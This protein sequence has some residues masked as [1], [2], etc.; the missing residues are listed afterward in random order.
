MGYM[1]VDRKGKRRSQKRIELGA[2]DYSLAVNSEC[3]PTRIMIRFYRREAE[4]VDVFT[5]IY[6]DI[7]EL[8][9]LQF[10]G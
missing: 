6:I 5:S 7:A 2:L 9:N 8:A 3:S 10:R 1:T 4:G